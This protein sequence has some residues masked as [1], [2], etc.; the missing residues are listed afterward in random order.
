MG[1]SGGLLRR[2]KARALAGQLQEDAV[3]AVRAALS[4]D[5]PSAEG[6]LCVR[7]A[8]LSMWCP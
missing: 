5:V 4:L 2:A 6:A 8:P 1:H 7:R 3:L